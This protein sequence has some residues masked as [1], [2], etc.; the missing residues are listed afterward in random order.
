MRRGMGYVGLV[1]TSVLR[2]TDDAGLQWLSPV[3]A[4]H[5]QKEWAP[6]EDHDR[7]CLAEGVC[8]W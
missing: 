5:Q 4:Q 2:A 3:F 7:S 1:L 8:W 6:K